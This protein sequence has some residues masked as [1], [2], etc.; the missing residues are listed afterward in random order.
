MTK[1]ISQQQLIADIYLSHRDELVGFACSRLGN[2]NEAEDLVQDVFLKLMEFS[3]MITEET[4]KSFVY[5]IATN[6]IKDVLRRRIFRHHAEEYVGY[7]RMLQYSSTERVVEH[8]E[9]IRLHEECIKRLSPACARVYQMNFYDDMRSGDI[10]EELHL[11][12]RT[13]ETHLLAARKK[14]RT[15]ISKVI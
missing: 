2:W 10:A 1:S 6:K 3:G 9:T 5:T 8:H 13:V 11:S 12:K 4:V 15:L 7:E 14:V